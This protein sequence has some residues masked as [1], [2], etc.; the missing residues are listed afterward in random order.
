[1][2]VGVKSRAESLKRLSRNLSLE[3]IEGIREPELQ[4][5]YFELK[6]EQMKT[7]KLKAEWQKHKNVY[8]SVVQKLNKKLEEEAERVRAKD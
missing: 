1:M 7:Q 8:I 6:L 3:E 5:V 4:E 2:S